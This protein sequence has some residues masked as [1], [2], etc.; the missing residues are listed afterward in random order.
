MA[1]KVSN[2]ITF[3][4]QKKIKEIKE[5]YLAT[6]QDTGITQ[7]TEGWTI[8][9]QTIAESKK[10]LWNYEE[11]IYTIGSS[12]VSNPVIIGVYGESG[13]AGA[14]LQVKYIS[15]ATV[16]IITNNDVSAWS[17]AV[18]EPVDGE[19]TYMTQ[20]MSNEANWST[21]IQISASDGKDG[22][23][24]VEINNDGYWVINGEITDVKAKGT[25][26][27]SPEITIG[28]NGNWYIDGVDSGTKAQGEAGKD[29]S[30]I[31]YVYY[32]SEKEIELSS[33]SY[34]DGVLT[35]G[36]T[37]S[38]QG[39]TEVY[40]C[41]YVAVRN[42][43]ADGD[44]SE[45]SDP[46]LWS[47]WGEKGQ[48]GD[49]VEYK[50]YLSNSDTVPTYSIGGDGWTDDPQG[51]SI[52]NQY[53]YVVQIKTIGEE[54]IASEPSLWAKYG[55]DGVGISTVKNY[56][57]VTQEAVLPDTPTWEDSAPALSPTNKYLW[58][59]E[60]IIYTNGE[61][62]P[63]DP[64]I[65]GV[66]GDSGTDA[67][68]FQIYSVDG[69]QFSSNL[70]TIELNTIAFQGGSKIDDSQ[71]SY[72]WKWWNSES[73]LDDKYEDIPD[74]TSPTLT[75]S[76]DSIYAFVSIKCEMEYDGIIYEDYVSLTQA[77]VVYTAVAKFFDGNNTITSDEEYLVVY[78][79]LYK[80]NNPEEQ[81][82]A[83]DIYISDI[84]EV[85]D[86]I[87][88]TDV[89]GTYV[90]GSLMY[91]VCKTASDDS[92][93]YDVVLGKYESSEWHIVTNNYIYK[94]DL[95]ENTTAPIVFISKENITRSITIN[96]EVYNNDNIIARTNAMV[97][98]LNDPTISSTAP[99]DPKEGQLW[100]DTSVSPSVLK[101]WDGTEWVNS[102]YQNGNVVYTSKPVNGYSEG[103]LWILE[104]EWDQYIAADNIT[105]ETSGTYWVIS[106][107]EDGNS[108]YVSVT[109]PDDYTDETVYYNRTTYGEGT[110]LK[111]EEDSD[112][113]VDSHWVDVDAEGTEQKKN[114]KQYFLFSADTG[115]RIGQ[116]DDLFYV[117]I[118]STE[119]GFY[120]ATNGTAQKVVSISN[121]SA[122]IKNLTVEE[123]ARFNCE[124]QFGNFILKTESN[125]SLSLAL[126]T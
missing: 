47:R 112:V 10:Y 84:N 20:K 61:S 77:T 18:P 115:L 23:A 21:P 97:L 70:T 114:I 102:G 122:T 92:V 100:L 91:F 34:T 49:G 80:D 3:T 123:G 105:S 45:F 53:E 48:D 72:Q 64:A 29:G 12:D 73:D 111:A 26:G 65:I 22:S 113:F 28:E 89:S 103:D 78:V 1:I 75:I 86:N 51:V 99:A 120:D 79:E 96:F 32:R 33:P 54:S 25:D 30:N 24:S 74:A 125:G 104:S 71:V 13:A 58:N 76:I 101:M 69:F 55:E 9:V 37:A 11:V 66:Y 60:E 119:M 36:W 43:P 88:T 87:I 40:K 41:E 85:N 44:W 107:D 52:H 98:D 19:K 62:I 68:D 108:E 17:D 118:S 42:K 6:N 109:L 81:L 124:V 8:T 63:T 121:Q 106:T 7:D 126:A 50:Y 39:I 116:S 56:Y 59:Y 93:E 35:S 82:Y 110:M 94:N 16:P 38:P 46:V 14:S 2:Q 83:D 15:S 67:V 4:E 57:L 95:F 117:N 90:D 27:S 5:W 31:E